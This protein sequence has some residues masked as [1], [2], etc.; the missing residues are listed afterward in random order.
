MDVQSEQ[1]W[2]KVEKKRNEDRIGFVV[3]KK[4]VCRVEELS[5]FQYGDADWVSAQVERRKSG[6]C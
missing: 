2:K 4:R 6:W 3:H 1:G 5:E